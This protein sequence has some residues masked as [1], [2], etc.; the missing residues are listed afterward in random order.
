MIKVYNVGQGDS[1]LFMPD[2]CMYEEDPILIDCGLSKANVYKKIIEPISKVLITHSHDDHIGGLE[3]VL[4]NKVITDVYIP[5]YLPEIQSIE[6]YL[7]K[8]LL[9]RSK[10]L[11]LSKMKHVKLH[12][13][14]D[15][16]KLCDH[17]TI[18]NPPQQP[19]YFYQDWLRQND[20]INIEIALENLNELG[21]NLPTE[22]I[23]NYT[24]PL[25]DEELIIN[26]EFFNFDEYKINSREF[27]HGFFNS[28]YI[29]ISTVNPSS[30]D[31]H[32]ASHVSLASNQASIVLKYKNNDDSC[33]FTGDADISVFERIIDKHG[34][35][36]LETNILKI[37]HHGSQENITE[38][39]LKMMNPKSVIVSHNNKYDHPCF[40][41]MSWFSKLNIDAY[42]TN[43][44]IKNNACLA[45]KT[46]GFCGNGKIEII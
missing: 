38:R 29:R 26:N 21:F 42:Y 32:T 23:L 8:K 31:F 5:Y 22:D 11:P 20:N 10:P 2:S 16:A 33:L 4:K 3:N 27:V 35:A 18:L 24:S 43:D 25:V 15:G 46:I 36:I 9:K 6:N 19:N 34:E 28:L 30:I 13:L 14:M 12:L 41:V 39:I 7:K 45:T 40:N 37:P 1:L 17:N 44:V